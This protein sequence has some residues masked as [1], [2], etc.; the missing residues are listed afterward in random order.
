MT[1]KK[2]GDFRLRI[3]DLEVGPE[4]LCHPE[5]RA[6]DVEAELAR[7]VREINEAT[8][9]KPRPDTFPLPLRP[10]LGVIMEGC[11]FVEVG[12]PAF[13]RRL[14]RRLGFLLDE[15]WYRV[16]AVVD[17][18]RR[19][20]AVVTGLVW[21]RTIRTYRVRATRRLDAKI[22]EMTIRGRIDF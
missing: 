18:F 9:G 10:R 22:G 19:G 20:R 14:A 21:D 12:R 2:I 1:S 7:L 3:G 5:A 8:E 6:E 16:A 4:A 15:D 17:A 13:D 11:G